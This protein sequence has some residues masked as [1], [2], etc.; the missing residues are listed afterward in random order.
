MGHDIC[1]IGQHK[2]NYRNIELLAKELSTI[3]TA[4]ID[5]GYFDSC[6]FN[7]VTKE[8]LSTYE[9]IVH[10]HITHP[11]ATNTFFL[12]DEYFNRRKILE[13]Y[14]DDLINILGVQSFNFYE[15]EQIKDNVRFEISDSIN[16]DDLGIIQND[17][18][19]CWLHDY[20]HRWGGFRRTFTTDNF[21]DP[22]LAEITK[23]RQSLFEF[24][25]K[26]GGNS[27]VYCDD[28]GKSSK[29]VMECY[30]WQQIIHE[31]ETVHFKKVYN[32]A[33]LIKSKKK[34]SPNFNPF[35]FFDD[36]SDLVYRKD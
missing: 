31:L 15:F 4:N 9:F 21:Q 12:S 2:L 17:T 13:Q 5:Y 7:P 20:E 6:Y 35:A 8:D 26:I 30:F 36:F 23:Y 33:K 18:F 3:F 25:K 16:D 22:K 28:Q 14:G 11:K 34:Y 32:V 10:G 19:Q 24:Y 1:P 29:Y 27:V